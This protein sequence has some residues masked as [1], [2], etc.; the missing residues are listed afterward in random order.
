MRKLDRTVVA[1]PACLVA[2]SHP[3]Q[4]WDAVTATDKEQVR[5][6][7]ELL[8]GRRCAYCEGDIDTLGQHI[9]HFRRKAQFPQLTFDWVLRTRE[10][11]LIST[12]VGLTFT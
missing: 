12:S 6:Q 7:L 8:Q 5:L 10:V 1:A 4:P 11:M 2:Y 3:A 9:E